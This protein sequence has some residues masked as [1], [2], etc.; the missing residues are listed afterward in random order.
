MGTFFREMWPAF[1][2][3]LLLFFVGCIASLFEGKPR[4]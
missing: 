4:A 1:M 3:V 2:V